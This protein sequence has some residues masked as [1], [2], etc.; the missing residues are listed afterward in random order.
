[1]KKK[2]TTMLS[3]LTV[4][5][6]ALAGC[7]GGAKTGGNSTEPSPSASTAPSA[8]PEASK[9]AEK[10]TINLRHTLVKE[11]NA[12]ELERLEQVKK[13]VEAKVP[14]LT[15][16][17]NGMEEQT[18]RY[19]RLRAEMSQGNPPHIFNLFGGTDTIDFA[20]TGN[21][22]DLTPILEELGLKDQFLNLGEFTVDGKVYG[23]PN[24]GYVE[25]I[26]YNKQIFKDAGVE[27]PKTWD[28]L[29]T[30][31]E[32][33]KSQGIV[34]FGLGAKDA[35]V[36]SMLFNTIW[37]RM[38]GPFIT[39]DIQAGEAKWTDPGLIEGYKK[40]KELAEK[41]YFSKGTLSL[42]YAQGQGDFQTGKAAMA[43]DGSW[44]GGTFSNPDL[45]PVAEHLGFFAFPTTG[46][47]GDKAINASYS[48]GYGFSSK[49]N[50]QELV[51]VKEFIKRFYS[52]E[53]QEK[54]HI[55]EGW[56]PSMNIT[57][58]SAKPYVNEIVAASAAA[59][60]TFPAFDA[61]VPAKVRDTIYTATQELIG[62]RITPEQFGEKIQKV[63][64][65]ADKEK[66]KKD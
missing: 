26:F 20:K 6:I 27:V 24:A 42:T 2:L 33:L 38:G 62:N 32:T 46:G 25:G 53:E 50:D 64:E 29:M 36:T 51:A 41:E 16:E 35:W 49:L 4:S 39:E 10:F 55:E 34:P 59:E 1:M 44:A 5:A 66:E 52:K 12:K 19:Q 17:L 13:D 7:G 31:S 15:I 48:N 45:T 14:G 18:H 63:Q 23:L 56:L 28:E 30:V 65:E 11:S 57:M 9:P 22:L 47:P 37:V 3:L 40:Y 8:T 21:L 61:V 58:S 54:Q 43:F 60:T